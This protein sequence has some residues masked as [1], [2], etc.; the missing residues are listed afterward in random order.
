MTLD[1]TKNHHV[2]VNGE[3]AAY[4]P[5]T[6]VVIWPRAIG[7]RLNYPV[8][9]GYS[10]WISDKSVLV[11]G[12]EIKF[13]GQYSGK[14][15]MSWSLEFVEDG[16]Y[17]EFEVYGCHT[18]GSP[19]TDWDPAEPSLLEL[20]HVELTKAIKYGTANGDVEIDLDAAGS[21]WVKEMEFH[22]LNKLEQEE[23]KERF[24]ISYEE[25]RADYDTYYDE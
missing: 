9:A 10:L 23:E 1:L 3:A 2:T 18:S 12:K 8:H 11:D 16:F 13:T 20:D 4:D 5:K 25:S 6:S 17:F 19:Q 7:T 15:L 22:I 14:F 24:C 21:Q